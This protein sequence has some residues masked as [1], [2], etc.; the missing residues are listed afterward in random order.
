MPSFSMTL[1]PQGLQRKP[2][3]RTGDITSMEWPLP[4]GVEQEFIQVKRIPPTECLT[5]E[6]SSF[7]PDGHLLPSWRCPSHL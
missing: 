1:Q 6:H 2:L 4:L 5:V 7:N 3:A